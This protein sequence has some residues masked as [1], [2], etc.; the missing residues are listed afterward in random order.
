MAK[1]PS[2]LS[3]R[4]FDASARHLSFTKAARE[5]HLTQSAVSRH[6]RHLEEHLGIPLFARAYRKIVLTPEGEAYKQDICSVFRQI[7]RA[8]S[9]LILAKNMQSLHIHSYTYIAT[10]WLVPRLKGFSEANSDIDFTLT[11]SAHSDLSREG[12]HGFIHTG[13]GEFLLA[14]K[15]FDINLVPVCAPALAKRLKRPRDLCLVPLLHSLA[16]PSNWST[17]LTGAGE[18]AVDPARGLH[19]ESTVMACAA[20]ISGLGVAMAHEVLVR[21]DLAA[22]SLVK[23]FNIAVSANRAYYFVRMP[24]HS[25]FRALEVFRSWL[26]AECREVNQVRSV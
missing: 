14:D 13:T 2:L 23:P 8:T 19:F 5:L 26:L 17:W 11:A 15:M 22:G 3:L 10:A 4:A 16:Y 6:I 7:E 20:A 9:R 25:S 21:S 24:D 12:V 18:T 1:L